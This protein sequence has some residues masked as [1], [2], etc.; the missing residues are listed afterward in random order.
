M[1]ATRNLAAAILIAVA[2]AACNGG[3][4]TAY[5]PRTAWKGT[6]QTGSAADGGASAGSDS[7]TGDGGSASGSDS[8][9]P[10]K[11]FERYHGGYCY[12][13]PGFRW[14]TF[15]EGRALCRIQGGEVAT[16]DSAAVDKIAYGLLPHLSSAAW[17]GLRRK[18]NDKRFGW[19]DGK[20]ASYRN[21]A[22]GEPN[23]SK[24]R[25]NCVVLWGPY[26][27]APLRSHWNDASCTAGYDSVICRREP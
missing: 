10:C 21:W 19:L 9:G 20:K 26:I 15:S 23:N 3:T 5:D 1:A 12:F 27:R 25:E 11:L 16:I 13:A 2:V 6:T 8:G 7:R 22:P 18:P 14:M 17:I 24:G 4:V